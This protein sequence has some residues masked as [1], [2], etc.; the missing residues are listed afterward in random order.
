MLIKEV[1]KRMGYN[2]N[3][4]IKVGATLCAALGLPRRLYASYSVCKKRLAL[5]TISQKPSH[6]LTN[7]VPDM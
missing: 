5:E 6:D 1:N 2:F 7:P 3:Q 4:F